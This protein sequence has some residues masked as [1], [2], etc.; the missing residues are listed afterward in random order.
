MKAGCAGP[1]GD[2]I[3]IVVGWAYPAFIEPVIFP[4]VAT[5]I[6]GMSRSGGSVQ[7]G[8]AMA[9]PSRRS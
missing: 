2:A 1:L 4:T 8:W 7:L 5:G 9:K 3:G 6:T